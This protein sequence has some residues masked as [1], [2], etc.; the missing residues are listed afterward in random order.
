[1][2][3]SIGVLL[4][5]DGVIIFQNSFLTCVDTEQNIWIGSFPEN[6]DC[7]VV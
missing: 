5:L 7:I 2:R 1:M 3:N 6:L 4:I